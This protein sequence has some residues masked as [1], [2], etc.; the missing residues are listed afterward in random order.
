MTDMSAIQ[1]PI[2]II[3]II[4][5]YYYYYY[6]PLLAMVKIKLLE[7]LR[8]H[9]MYDHTVEG[10]EN[11]T[12]FYHNFRSAFPKCPNGRYKIHIF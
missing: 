12:I 6:N 1:E 2:I 9:K 5:N 3:I 7:S 8:K 4:I 10:S 11:Q